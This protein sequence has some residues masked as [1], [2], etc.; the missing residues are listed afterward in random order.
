MDV[1]LKRWFSLLALTLVLGCFPAW[2]GPYAPAAGTPGTTAIPK[3][4]AAFVAWAAGWEN[5]VMGAELDPAYA[6]PAKALGPAEGNSL[7]VVSLGRAGEITLVFAPF[8]D[9]PGWDFAVFENGF[10][11]T[12][13]ELARVEVSSDGVNF[14]RFPATSLTAAPVSAFG[15]LD[16]TDVDGLAGKY[17][18]GYGTP[19]DLSDLAAAPLV[20]AG[21]VDLSAITRV[22]IIDVVGDGSQKDSSGRPIYDPYP[23]TG[24]AGF[25][26][27]AVGVSGG[28]SYPV[29]TYTPPPAPAQSGSAGIGDEG[30]CFL[31]TAWGASLPGKP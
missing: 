18:Q 21:T 22:R 30:G 12:F 5:F 27:D 24:S 16:P 25:D 28:A 10:S 31:G 11:D 4:S 9:G 13:L 14:A 6:D 19:F 29:G 3:D 8:S 26:I 1:S 7:D 23:T 2:A 20:A 15:A 17:R